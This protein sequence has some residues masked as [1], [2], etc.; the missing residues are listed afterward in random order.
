MLR[1]WIPLNKLDFGTVVTDNQN[2]NSIPL[3]KKEFVSDKQ[4]DQFV[5]T[6]HVN[7]WN[8]CCSHTNDLLFLQKNL[9]KLNWS[10]VSGNPIAIDL[11]L[12]NL[13]LFWV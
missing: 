2:V 6:L 8:K 9:H 12:K 13:E 3:I 5:S 4:F 10:A 1:H 11:L 7:D